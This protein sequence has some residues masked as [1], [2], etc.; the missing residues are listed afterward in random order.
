MDRQETWHSRNTPSTLGLNASKG[1]F[2]PFQKGVKRPAIWH[3]RYQPSLAK[4][5]QEEY[6]LKMFHG[7]IFGWTASDNRFY[8]SNRFAVERSLYT[9]SIFAKPLG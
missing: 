7:A 4:L 1:G 9:S 5:W 8:R 6:S 3:N 2:C